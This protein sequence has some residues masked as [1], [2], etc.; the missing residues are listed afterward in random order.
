MRVLLVE[1]SPYSDALADDLR[2]R[3]HEV[4]IVTTAVAAKAA[5]DTFG[6][7]V[8]VLGEQLVDGDGLL[9]ISGLATRPLMFLTRNG[10]QQARVVALKLG[11]DAVVDPND[12]PLLEARMLAIK[13]SYDSR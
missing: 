11:A 5:Y 6:P 9:E 3:E 10:K 4:L 8:V 1:Y 2:Q 13:R 7:D 12:V